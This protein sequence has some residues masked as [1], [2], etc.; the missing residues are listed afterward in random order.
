MRTAT[1]LLR[2]IAMLALVMGEVPASALVSDESSTSGAPETRT[3]LVERGTTVDAFTVPRGGVQEDLDPGLPVEGDYMG[4]AAFT[5][6]GTRLLLTNRLTD[7]VTVYDAAT[8]S[9]ITNVAVGTSP[10]GIAVT[11]DYAVV[12]CAFSDEVYVIDLADYSIDAVIPTGEQPW[13]VRT[14][15]DGTRAYVACDIDDVCEVLDLTTLTHA[16]TIAGFP[17]ALSL[18]SLSSENARSAFKFTSFQVTP[19]GLL[20]TGDF[21]DS[22]LF[23]DPVTGLVDATVAGVPGIT[24]VALS[25]DGT[26][27][28]AI[29]TG[30]TPGRAYQIDVASR[31]LTGT[32]TFSDPVSNPEVAVN[33]D[34]TKAFVG[35]F[36]N[37]SAI[38][39]FATG[40][41]VNIAST[42]SP[43]WVAVT[44]D[45]AYAIS[46]QFRFSII[47]FAS[48]SQ[49]A[50]LQGLTQSFGAVAF[51]T[52]RV[53]GYDPLRNEGVYFYDLSVPTTPSFVAEAEAGEA[54]EGDCPRRVALTPDGQT[55]VVA[56]VLSGNVS[57][58][59]VPTR[60]VEAILPVGDRVQNVA[61]TSDGGTAVACGM[62]SGA[63]TII[64]LG[65]NAV[66]ANVPTGTRP[67]VVVITPDDAFAYV[68][69]IQ[70]NTVSV[71]ELDGAASSEVTELPVGVIGVQ[72]L[73]FGINSGLAMS[74]T[75][76]Y[77]LVAASFD[78]QVKVIAT[79]SR[80]IV[81]TLNVGDFPLQLAFTDDGTRALVT[82]RFDDTASLLAIDG[83]SSSVVTSVALPGSPARLAYDAN[84]E[85]G[86]HFGVGLVDVSSVVEI[87]PGTGAITGTES[88]A[89]FGTILEVRYDQLGGSVVLTSSN[90]TDPGHLHLATY[91][92]TYT[93]PA[94]PSFFDY[95]PEGPAPRNI[96]AVAMPGPDFVTIIERDSPLGTP[97]LGATPVRPFVLG[98]PAP[99]PTSGTARF[100]FA[101]ARSSEIELALFDVSGRRVSVLASGTREAGRHDVVLSTTGLGA[102]TYLVA[103]RADGIVVAR[104]KLVVVSP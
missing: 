101:L 67:G 45:H 98:A 87:D 76:E 7:N 40:D 49:V 37:Q 64:D 86:G 10:G 8:Q 79:T 65:T 34:G 91:G 9:L 72:F 29:N 25:G 58:I 92:E 77:V 35:L 100:A 32:V 5:T 18:A 55:A 81:A 63:V 57:I 4:E 12:A 31:S 62:E 41:A 88:F 93:L 75:G 46:G 21:D 39:R 78:D 17:I 83:A 19:G 103:L 74:P 1:T 99:N 11:D 13:V 80:T 33:A 48:E 95:V 42:L 104:E 53:A 73:G 60:T 89:G 71:V 51:S 59:D 24:A 66:L 28:V 16:N 84:P 54:P 102:G 50:Q 44:A 43:Q 56:N 6:D 94:G 85:F 68:A 70:S 36:G 61:I 14:S 96:V 15:M 82:N 22:V 2:T 97:E 26:R 47:D 27:A 69:N 23:F 38:A 52:N 90:G 30:Q 3:I 20:V